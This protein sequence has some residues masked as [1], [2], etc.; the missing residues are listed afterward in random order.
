[1][2]PAQCD[3][4]LYRGDYFEMTL[5]LREGTFNGTG[6]V[7]GAYLDLTDWVPKAEIRAT[8]DTTGTPMA[9]FTTEI[10]DQVAT[11]AGAPVPARGA[12]RRADGGDRCLGRPAHRPR[13]AG[14]HLP[15]RRGGDHEGRDTA[16]TVTIT[17]VSTPVVLVEIQTSTNVLSMA[18]PDLS[19]V[20]ITTASLPLRVEVVQESA[21]LEIMDQTGPQGPPGPPGLQKVVHG[22]DP[23][24]VRPDVPLVYWVG[25]VQPVNADPDDLLMLKEA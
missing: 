22:S 15:A 21:Y 10:L 16:M 13:R 3:I 20:E 5:R 18:A 11:P 6:Y 19:V 14:A 1:M 17:E 25:T 8:V 24:V 2:Q 12:E 9:T 23:N 4:Q 7:P